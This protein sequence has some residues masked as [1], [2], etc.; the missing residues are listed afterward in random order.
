[1]RTREE[2]SKHAE[3]CDRQAEA[4]KDAANKMFLLDTA[5]EWR[6]LA[7]DP[8]DLRSQLFMRTKRIKGGFPR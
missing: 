8:G 6:K 3:F 7:R 4:T 5:E 2:C 1:M